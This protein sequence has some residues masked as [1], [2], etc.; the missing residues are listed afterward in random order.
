MRIHYG[1]N[2]AQ[3]PYISVDPTP[4]PVYEETL[5]AS[6][7]TQNAAR[8]YAEDFLENMRKQTTWTESWWRALL[9]LFR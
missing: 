3:I 5:G 6:W 2:L 4:F 1:S 7:M 9:D 8:R